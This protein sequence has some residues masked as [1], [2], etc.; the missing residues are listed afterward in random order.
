VNTSPE[1]DGFICY[2]TV[3]SARYV[4]G[5]PFAGV[6]YC[7]GND[8]SSAHA[9][10]RLQNR[11]QVDDLLSRVDQNLKHYY[12]GSPY[13]L[14]SARQ[15]WEEALDI[16][17]EEFFADRTLFLRYI[18]AGSGGNRYAVGCVGYQN[19]VL[20]V[21]I[22]LTSAGLTCDMAAW[23][24]LVEAPKAAVEDCTDWFVYSTSSVPAISEEI[25]KA[26]DGSLTHNYYN[27]AGMV[28]SPNEEIHYSF[29]HVKAVVFGEAANAIYNGKSFDWGIDYESVTYENY[30]PIGYIEVCFVLPECTQT[31]A[32]E[33]LSRLELFNFVTYASI[34]SF[35]F[36][37]QNTIPLPTD[38]GG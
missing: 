28:Y 36:V 1:P 9:L 3:V 38:V 12:G 2:S 17:D 22:K 6:P 21:N 31:K 35:A 4:D 25:G 29:D 14:S 37:P 16:Y 13:T 24:V 23:L 32:V 33:A 30:D 26:W 5:Q 15:G 27:K 7:K 20:T 19:G 10:Y 11:E 18:V 8:S 34:R